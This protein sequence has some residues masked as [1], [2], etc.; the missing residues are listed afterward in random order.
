MD[1]Y[2]QHGAQCGEKIT[3]G[4]AAGVLNGVI[5]GAK[6][7]SGEKLRTDLSQIA[8]TWPA[9]ARLF[10]PHFYATLIAAQ[11]G[12]RLG[13]LIGEKGH[14]Y[15]QAHLR[16]D[17]EEVGP[18]QADIRACLR[19]QAALPL[20]ALISPNI[21]IRRSFDSVEGVVAKNFI[22]NAKAI[23][24][25]VSPGRK[26]YAT[27]AISQAALADKTELQTFLQEIT[28]TENPPDG[29]YLLLEKLDSNPIPSLT[30]PD[31]LSRW[32]LINYSLKISGF[33]VINGYTDLLSP[34]IAATGADAVASGWFSTLK[35]FSLRKFEP[36]DSFPARPVPRYSSV[37]L[38]KSIRHTELHDIRSSFPEILN[39]LPSDAFYPVT[40]GSRPDVK[41]EAVQNWDAIKAMIAKVSKPTVPASVAACS[42]ALDDAGELYGSVSLIGYSLRERSNGEHISAIRDELSEF[43]SLA[44]L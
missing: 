33:E 32:M 42:A 25:E 24:N 30:E 1:L 7:I 31:C 44:E 29:F 19:F 13:Y 41:N 40:D 6:E 28:E 4:L 9:A 10:D 38:L 16:R 11:P 36:A 35:S 5:F 34:Y 15:F 21:V 37:S 12:A 39:G 43:S 8:T 3:A 17:L 14:G 22:R 27:L 18:L 2:A 23:G 26:V 20:T